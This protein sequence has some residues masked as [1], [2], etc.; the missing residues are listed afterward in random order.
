MYL[1][2]ENAGPV[3]QI[4]PPMRFLTTRYNVPPIRYL[5]GYSSSRDGRVT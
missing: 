4:I 3:L 5:G 1:R 2:R